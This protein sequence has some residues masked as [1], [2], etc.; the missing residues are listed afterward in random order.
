MSTFAVPCESTHCMGIL[1]WY[2]NSSHYMESS[3]R[4]TTDCRRRLVTALVVIRE[5]PAAN[6]EYVVL[7]LKG[8]SLRATIEQQL[9]EAGLRVQ[10]LGCE[11]ESKDT[12]TAAQQAIDVAAQLDVLLI[13]SPS[14]QHISPHALQAEMEQLH[15][16]HSMLAEAGKKAVV[17]YAAQPRHASQR[18][19]L[20]A[21]GN[22]TV[23]S[24]FGPYTACGPLCQTQV[25]WLEGMLAILFMALAACAGEWHLK[26]GV[27]CVECHANHVNNS[28]DV[29]ANWL[30]A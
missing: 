27:W 11:P 23:Y 13:C 30:Q 16:L 22:A 8:P 12:I 9:Q 5:R 15:A 26:A 17:V 28:L 21:A 2:C 3:P 25:R 6:L 14:S 19:S 20:Q 4:P 18:R 29:L 24:G 1:E 7:D 10:V